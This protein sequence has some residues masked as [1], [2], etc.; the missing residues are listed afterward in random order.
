MSSSA[1][2]S[3]SGGF[4]FWQIVLPSTS[5]DIERFPVRKTFG[6]RSSASDARVRNTANMAISS[7]NYLLLKQVMCRVTPGFPANPL[8][9]VP[10]VM[11]E[12]SRNGNLRT[13]SRPF[14]IARER[15]SCFNI[16]SLRIPLVARV[17]EISYTATRQLRLTYGSLICYSFPV[18]PL[19]FALCAVS[20]RTGVHNFRFLSSPHVDPFSAV[21]GSSKPMQKAFTHRFWRSLPGVQR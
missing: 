11:G 8:P 15:N 18:E 12:N 14:D 1:A 16:S 10:I 7:F 3:D 5:P 2:A 4:A 20:M 21:F 17:P 6:I 19:T 13:F 9:A